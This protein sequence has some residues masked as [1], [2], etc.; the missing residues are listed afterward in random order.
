MRNLIMLICVLLGGLAAAEAKPGPQPGFAAAND[1]L[2]WI[3][4]YLDHPDPAGVPAAYR[5]LSKFE[6]MKDPENSGVYVGFLAGV[7]GANPG[8]APTL[9][10]ELLPLPFEDQWVLIEAISYSGV[11]EWQDLLRRVAPRMPARHAMIEGYL[12]GKLPPLEAISLETRSPGTFVTVRDFLTFRHKPP[13]AHIV[14]FDTDPQ[15]LDVLWGQYFAT[16]D[17]KPIDRI[18][19]ML[20]WSKEAD[21][22]DRLTIGSMAKYTLATNASR[23]AALLGLLEQAKYKPQPEKVKLVLD[24][25]VAAAETDDT[26]RIH[27][28]AL[29][30]I[31]ELAQ[32]GPGS[33]RDMTLWGQLGEGAISAGCITAAATGQEYLGIPCVVGGAL[34]AGALHYFA[35]QP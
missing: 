19:A 30:A 14:T 7:L 20:S 10:D 4:R 15:L 29:A 21:N 34:S 1:V 17:E 18:I 24:E 8:Q 12:T 11:S 9:V 23:A 6:V 22:S 31:Q 3:N 2:G 26:A 28:E 32:K 5:A 27:K 35:G 16:G 33:K 25:V 13:P